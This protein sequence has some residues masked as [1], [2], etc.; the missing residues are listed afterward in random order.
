VNIR[1]AENRVKDPVPMRDAY[2]KALTEIA[3]DN[4]NIVA[5]DADLASCIGIPAL[6]KAIPGRLINCGIQESNMM[7]VAAGLSAAGKIPYVH[8][9]G[10]FA[11]RRVFDQ[12]FLSIAYAKLNVRIIG[13]DPGVT[14]AYNGGTHMP[15]EDGALMRTI[16]DAIVM[17]VADTVMMADLTRKIADIYGLTY[18][19]MPRKDVVKVYE[20]GSSFTIG[21]ACTLREGGDVTIIA[22]GI[23]VPEALSAAEK[24]ETEGIHAAV[25]DLFTWKPIDREAIETWAGKTGAIVTAENHNIIGGLGSAVAEVLS[26][27]VPVPMER[28]GSRDRFGQ[29]GPQGFLMK[30]Y[31]MLSS[32]IE[33][34]VRKV[35]SRK[36]G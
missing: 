15:F 34:A 5:L 33:A 11:T 32:D 26:E 1:L 3:A 29:V 14:A 36:K 12:V 23:L 22:S 35:L 2:V 6:E 25:L 20:E 21:K 4:P 24:L 7:G 16:P 10:P 13:S 9:F 27:T 31:N 18:V 28:V 30:E 19:R 8:T 17:D